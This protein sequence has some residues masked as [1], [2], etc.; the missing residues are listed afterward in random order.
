MI[1]EVKHFD[2]KLYNRCKIQYEQHSFEYIF[3]YYYPST[4]CQV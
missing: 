1:G 2:E 3:K 4:E